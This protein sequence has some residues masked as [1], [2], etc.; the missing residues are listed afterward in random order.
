MDIDTPFTYGEAEVDLANAPSGW[1]L[2]DNR[3]G[4]IV[5]P[6]TKRQLAHAIAARSEGIADRAQEAAGLRAVEL[7]QQSVDAA[8]NGDV[9]LSRRLEAR[10]WELLAASNSTGEPADVDLSFEEIEDIVSEPEPDTSD[11]A[12]LE[13]W[14][15][16]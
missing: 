8:L 7:S 6:L 10:A 15:R 3:T 1:A 9:E 2:Q 12:L 4:R 5:A 14:D 13:L 11:A 16:Q